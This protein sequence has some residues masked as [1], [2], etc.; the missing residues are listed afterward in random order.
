MKHKDIT[1]PVYPFGNDPWVTEKDG[2]YYYCFSER[3]SGLGVLLVAEIPSIAEITTENASVVY[4]APEETPYSEEYWAPELHYIDGSWYIYF[5]ADDGNN[6]NHRM[7]VLRGTCDDPTKPFE[8]VGKITDPTNKWAIDGT[9]VKIGGENYFV[10]SG[11]EG[12]VNVA[13][14]IY[15]AHMKS[16]VEIDSNRT[17]I[18]IPEYS[19]ETVGGPPVINEGPAALY[20]GDN[21]FITYSASGS[22]TDDYCLG[23][24]EYIG[25]NPLEKASWKKA[26]APVFFKKEN[27]AYGTG[28]CSFAPAHDGSLWM[29]YHANP[30]SGTGWDGRSV[31]IAPIE[32]GVDG[33]PVFG[34]P[35]TNV[36]FP[37]YTDKR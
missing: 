4:S 37:F 24:L 1:N 25:G 17:C 22:W 21:V 33:K 20:N 9:V 14:N 19:W 35:K 11:W 10:W 26:E 27:V 28:H 8:M 12:D 32:F 2:K 23:L 13:Q 36:S 15:I 18:S 7:Y 34:N 5:A 16:P 31:W 30:V 3:T 6:D 29:I